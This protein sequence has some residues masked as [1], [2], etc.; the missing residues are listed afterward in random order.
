MGSRPTSSS[1]AA[2]AATHRPKPLGGISLPS[3]ATS[4]TSSTASEPSVMRSPRSQVSHPAVDRHG[5]DQA[6]GV[7][8]VL[9]DQVH[10]SGGTEPR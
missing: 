6:V 2:T 10:P 4:T 9:A 7:I 3:A 5:Q 1:S 8:G